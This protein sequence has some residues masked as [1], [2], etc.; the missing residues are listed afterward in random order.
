MNYSTMG[1]DSHHQPKKKKNMI[2]ILQ[3]CNIFNVKFTFPRLSSI[4][5]WHAGIVPNVEFDKCLQGKTRKWRKK[6]VA[7]TKAQ[8]PFL[9]VKTY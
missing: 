6:H 5:I 9:V 7:G 2:I 4:L 3:G 1:F 8:R